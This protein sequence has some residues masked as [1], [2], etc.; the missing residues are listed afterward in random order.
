MTRPVDF[1]LFA[2]R[3]TILRYVPKLQAWLR[4]VYLQRT[5]SAIPVDND[6]ILCRILGRTKFFVDARD[7][8]ISPHLMMDGCWEPRITGLLID[9]LRFGMTVID[10]GAN[11]GYFTV[12]MALLCGPRGRVIAFEPNPRIAAMLRDSVQINGLQSRVDFHQQVVGATD[13][14]EVNLLLS[15]DHPGGT[16]ITALAPDGPNF[17]KAT[18]RRLDGFPGAM[19]ATLVKI[20]AEGAEEM[21][22]QGMSAMIAGECLRY[23][24]IEFSPASYH[25]APGMLNQAEAAGFSI[26]WID[27]EYGL[28]PVSRAEIFD[29]SPLRMLFLSR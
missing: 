12:L 6:T 18:T 21:I 7:R 26:A 22:W 19:E 17:M 20:D 11:L 3:R 15:D 25:D 29:G 2:N 10:V 28:R 13:G 27:E 9:K 4:R 23:I 5:V 8:S 1:T 24:I 16:Q 14:A